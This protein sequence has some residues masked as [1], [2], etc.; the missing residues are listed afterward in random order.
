MEVCR[1]RCTVEVGKRNWELLFD[2][3]DSRDSGFMSHA[4]ARMLSGG[5]TQCYRVTSIEKL[6]S[7]VL[8]TSWGGGCVC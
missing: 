4:V 7:V 1:S 2:D 8:L 6:K 5:V 3:L